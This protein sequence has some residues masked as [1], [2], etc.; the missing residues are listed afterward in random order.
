[1]YGDKL[2]AI[3]KAI[4]VTKNVFIISKCKTKAILNDFIRKNY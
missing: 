1:M 3:G 4:I 2:R